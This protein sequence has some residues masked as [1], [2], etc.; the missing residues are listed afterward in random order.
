ML[1]YTFCT[2]TFVGAIFG[3]LN[4]V[5]VKAWRERKKIHGKH[6]SRLHK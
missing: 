5:V 1:L 6:F 4:V 2:A 3:I